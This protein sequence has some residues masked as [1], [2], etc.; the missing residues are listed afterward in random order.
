[1]YI[2][3][4]HISVDQFASHLDC[5]E[6]HNETVKCTLICNSKLKVTWEAA[7]FYQAE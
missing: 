1:M 6:K 3:L 2:L 5:T 4:K 7:K